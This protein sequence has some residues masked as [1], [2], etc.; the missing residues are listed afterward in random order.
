MKSKLIE[1]KIRSDVY[2]LLEYLAK[3]KGKSVNLY[4]RDIILSYLRAK[5]YIP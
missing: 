4:C 1:F 2:D 3:S 5:K